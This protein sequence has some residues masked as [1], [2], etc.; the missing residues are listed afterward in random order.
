MADP[1]HC[2]S[3]Y[4][5]VNYSKHFP[6]SDS[7]FSAE[8]SGSERYVTHPSRPYPSMLVYWDMD[9]VCRYA[10][11]A[12]LN[13][14]QHKKEDVIDRMRLTDFVGKTLYQDN[15]SRI[16]AAQHGKPARFEKKLE[17][18]AGGKLTA[19]ISLMPDVTNGRTKGVYGHAADIGQIRQS[20]DKVLSDEKKLLHAVIAIQ[21][22]E[23][24]VIAEMLR[25]NVN[26]LL[27][28]VSLMMQ[29]K[30]MGK[31]NQRFTE[32]MMQ[33]IQQAI[34]EL[35]RL[36]SHLYPSGLSLLGLI[37]SIESL[38]SEYRSDYGM[39]IRFLAPDP[40]MEEL[41]H[42]EKLSVFRIIQDYLSLLTNNRQFSPVDIQ[43]RY[44]NRLLQLQI[45][46]QHPAGSAEKDSDAYRDIRSR[47][48]FYNGHFREYTTA[49]K[50]IFRA[51]LVFPGVTAVRN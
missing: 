49:A 27:V 43:L 15:Q 16:L 32:D 12:A 1:D 6:M 10:N 33:T 7:G 14:F 24:S 41:A 28:Y 19:L 26:Q 8:D 34:L 45:E 38:L 11:D 29:G 3:I 42:D 40:R 39:D 35:N 47:I 9:Q 30:T 37:P 50:R 17:S 22:K 51:R 25:D 21:E 44:R 48:E 5:L 31:D 18:P 13:W 2:F 46:V 23:R 4:N 20:A 36:S